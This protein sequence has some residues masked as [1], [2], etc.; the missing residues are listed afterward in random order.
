MH[1]D[2]NATRTR[3]SILVR[4][5]RMFFEGKLA[6]S[7]D[8]IPIDMRPRKGMSY[9]CCVY[10]DRAI[11]KYRI[12]AALGYGMEDEQSELDPLKSYVDKS[13]TREG[14]AEGEPL[15]LLE[16]ACSACVKSKYFV[17][18]ACRGCMARPC[19]L[20]CPKKAII[21][22][23]N[24]QAV[25]DSSKCVNCG[26][27]MKVC[28]YHS[29]IRIPVPCEEACPAGAIEKDGQGRATIDFDKCILCG[30]CMRECP[31]G[32]IMER[33]QIIDVLKA[34]RSGR[35]V[36]VIV[37]P[38]ATAQFMADY[39]QLVSA[40][41]TIGFADVMEVAHGATVTSKKEAEELEKRL[42]NGEKFM[43]NSCCPSYVRAVR[44]HLPFLKDRISDTASPMHYTARIIK[45]KYPECAVV[46]AGPCVAK[47]AEAKE[48]SFVDFVLTC[49]ELA[50]L[51][52]AAGIDV[53]GSDS[54]EAYE[55]APVLSRTFPIS[56]KVTE[57]VAAQMK[58]PSLVKG[59]L[60]DGLDRKSMK[61][62]KI[63]SSK[64]IKGNFLEVMACEGGCINGPCTTETAAQARK[65]VMESCKKEKN[66]ALRFEEVP[67]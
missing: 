54:D 3:R 55:D 38:A 44:K 41:K 49:E 61:L 62:L 26:I 53:S 18:N 63:I 12:M 29:I 36:A 20:N 64:G 16:E 14:P 51:F 37:A 2:N 5:A 19:T 15:S 9:R 30:K 43:T 11:I 28:P 46:F 42:E 50:S 35:R 21:M 45:D 22:N 47:R 4:I 66:D 52:A 67:D 58:D 48:D 40:L 25:I 17:T 57:A 1:F 65:R 32:A 60:I 24:G 39:S 6:E 33:S 23:E 31:F 56:G 7:V 8:S 34:V 13:L 59:Q 27:C 10:K